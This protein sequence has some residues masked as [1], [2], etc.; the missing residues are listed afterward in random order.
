MFFLILLV[1]LNVLCRAYSLIV[2]NMHKNY[3]VIFIKIFYLRLFETLYK[4][5][6]C[7][8]ILLNLAFISKISG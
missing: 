6:Y 3:S 4:S 1:K 5:H 8:E 7:L 2:T